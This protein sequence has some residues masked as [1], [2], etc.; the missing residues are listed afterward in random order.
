VS[1]KLTYLDEVQSAVIPVLDPSIISVS[2]QPALRFVVRAN[3]EEST[4]FVFAVYELNNKPVTVGQ[5]IFFY[6]LDTGFTVLGA[7]QRANFTG[8]SR[9]GDR[10]SN[11]L[12]NLL[13]AMLQ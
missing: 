8:H 9:F 6:V 5:I 7:R 12:H 11:S 1:L 10:G 4:N 2:I 13:L 3:E